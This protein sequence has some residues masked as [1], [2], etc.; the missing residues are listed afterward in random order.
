MNQLLRN[1][2]ITLK[3]SLAPALALLG[4]VI[5][6]AIG[7]LGTRALSTDLDRLG[8]QDV[9]Q[10]TAAEDLSVRMTQIQ[11]K[12]YQS[13]TWEAVGM[14]AETLK[15]FDDA[16]LTD[17]KRFGET[18]DPS[19]L[20]PASSEEEKR[21]GAEI[22]KAFKVY[23][24]TAADTLDMKSAGVANAASYVVTLDGQY[25][26][27]QALVGQF[28]KRQIDDA[29]AAV[30]SA[31]AQAQRR[32]WI[33]G[34]L[35]LAVL[36]VATWLASIF[37]RAITRPLAR[38]AQLADSL[39]DGDLTVRH[40]TQ[41]ADATGRVLAALDKVAANLAG[42]VQDIRGTAEQINAASGD[43]A[44]GNSDLSARTE[45]TASALQEAAASIE[46]LATTIRQSADNARAAS[47][48]ATEASNVARQ[49][50]DM[51]TDV[52][53]TMTAIN[54]S[55][56]KIADI[57]G[58]IDGIAFQ[59]NILALNAAVEAARAGEQ[60]RG[61]AVVAG[62][63]R[64]L[65]QRSGDAAREIRTL[66]SSSVEQI[67]AGAAKAQ[68]AG[69]TM[70]RIVQS[71]EQVSSTVADISRSADEQAT[72]IA[73]VNQTVAEMDR[74]TQQNAAMVEQASAATE[75]LSAQADS[76][77]QMLGR[78]RTR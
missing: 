9:P 29:N 54:G 40:S 4:L 26:T 42:L 3:V 20:D 50:G 13:L 36:A 63:V 69:Q 48:L 62:E 70:T 56:R 44:S 32:L 19:A 17:I 77:V 43:I 76:L 11:E 57:I 28:L 10:I 15:T 2:S 68:N 30:A 39:A 34:G 41:G 52:V 58:V 55:A 73:Q 24:R 8:S 49:G 37:V 72:G 65:A 66:I 7:V 25:K 71:I 1:A 23:A 12:V 51:V 18:P 6:A 78:F 35:S 59:T 74:N 53:Q 38:A 21:M 27:N 46:E 5:V 31:R 47:H 14:R 22:V 60:G 33:I 61:F 16:L 67:E 45:N 75:S 64:T